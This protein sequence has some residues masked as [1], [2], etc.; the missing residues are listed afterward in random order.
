MFFRRP[1]TEYSRAPIT[2]EQHDYLEIACTY[3]LVIT[4]E[5]IGGE[6]RVLTPKDTQITSDKV[7]WLIGVGYPDRTEVKIRTDSIA[8]ISAINPNPH[9]DTVVFKLR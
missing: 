4:I 8:L 9:F 6:K 3:R 2:C 7:E 1:V 5:M